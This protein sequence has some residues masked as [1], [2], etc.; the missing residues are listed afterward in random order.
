M[1]GFCLATQ[2]HASISRHTAHTI[3]PRKPENLL[4]PPLLGLEALQSREFRARVI[5]VAISSSDIRPQPHSTST[6]CRLTNLPT[7]SANSIHNVS[8]RARFVLRGPDPRRRRRR[9]HRTFLIASPRSTWNC[10]FS[11]CPALSLGRFSFVH[12]HQYGN[13]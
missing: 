11:R 6:S 4:D 3:N 5:S 13:Q 8:R 7:A 2:S 10:P 1:I 9:D 12:S